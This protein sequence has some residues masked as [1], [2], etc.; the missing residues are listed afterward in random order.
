MHQG[1]NG[2]PRPESEPKPLTRDDYLAPLAM[3]AEARFERE[4]F[5]AFCAGARALAKA[6][7]EAIPDDVTLG[8]M[9]AQWKHEQETGLTGIEPPC[10]SK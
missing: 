1:R 2:T 10:T 9:W 4:S 6:V 5:Q 3:Y 7:G 8:A